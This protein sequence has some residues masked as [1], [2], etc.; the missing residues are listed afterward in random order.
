MPLEEFVRWQSENVIVEPPLLPAIL[1]NSGSSAIRRFSQLT[2]LTG[3]RA[4]AISF[5]RHRHSAPDEGASESLRR[6]H[7]STLRWRAFSFVDALAQWNVSNDLAECRIETRA[8]F[9]RRRGLS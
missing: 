2:L 3:L 1:R 6:R 8:G 4:R 7:P 9:S 5:G